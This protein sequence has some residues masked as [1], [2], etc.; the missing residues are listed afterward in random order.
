LSQ[1][2]NYKVANKYKGEWQNNLK[3]GYG[4]QIY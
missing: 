4:V 2:Q 3:N 1:N